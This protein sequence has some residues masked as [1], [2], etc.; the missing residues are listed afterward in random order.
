MERLFVYG[1][2][3]PGHSNAH[4]LENIG[5]EWLPGYVTGTFY[6]RGW[7]TAADFPGIVLDKD[8]ALVHGYVFLSDKLGALWPILDEFEDGYD[9]VEVEVTT[10]DG[11]H[12]TAWIY[13]LQPQTTP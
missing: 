11:Q 6:E 2:L 10:A 4:I 13:Q 3:R 1:T 7:G 12:V 8:G 9:R 5:G